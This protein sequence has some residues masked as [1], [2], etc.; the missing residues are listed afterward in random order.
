MKVTLATTTTTTAEWCCGAE[1]VCLPTSQSMSHITWLHFRSWNKRCLVTGLKQTIIAISIYFGPKL[2]T[3]RG[4]GNDNG[5]GRER[6]LCVPRLLFHTCTFM[7]S[8][9]LC[10]PGIHIY[11]MFV[12]F[13]DAQFFFFFFFFRS[14]TWSLLSC[15]M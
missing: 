4:T 13:V 3:K 10:L 6:E 14:R 9:R 11:I 2:M 15:L 1:P 8:C 12:L 5:S 7:L